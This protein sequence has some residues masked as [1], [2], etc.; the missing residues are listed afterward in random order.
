MKKATLIISLLVITL[1]AVSCGNNKSDENDILTIN[2]NTKNEVLT[3]KYSGTIPAADGPGIVY[4]V[5]LI[6]YDDK[7]SGVYH[8]RQ[9]YIDAADNRDMAFDYYGRFVVT[10]KNSDRIVRLTPFNKQE[11]AVNFIKDN[12][13]SITLLDQQMNRIDSN[14]NYTLRRVK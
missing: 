7:D 4:E 9:T 3:E 2:A 6:R 11:E 10:R 13:S 14:L 5:T 1:S 12:D 8:M